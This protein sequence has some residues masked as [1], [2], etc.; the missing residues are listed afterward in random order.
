[1]SIKLCVYTCLVF[2]SYVLLLIIYQLKSQTLIAVDL[3][4]RPLLVY[5]FQLFAMKTVKSKD[6]ISSKYQLIGELFKF[7]KT[8]QFILRET[9]ISVQLSWRSIV[10]TF[11]LNVNNAGGANV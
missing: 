4:I 10:K 8:L 11:H 3:H 1:M 9:S 7:F 5:W 6:K 2:A